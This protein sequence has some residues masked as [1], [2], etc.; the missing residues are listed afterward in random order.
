MLINYISGKGLIITTLLA[1]S[2]FG[3]VAATYVKSN[4]VGPKAVVAKVDS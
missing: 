4:G 3:T 1:S 2:S